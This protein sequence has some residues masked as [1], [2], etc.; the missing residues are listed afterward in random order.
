M[1]IMQIRYFGDKNYPHSQLL[2]SNYPA[3]ITA[4]DLIT[5][6]IFNKYMPVK[7]LVINALPGTRFTIDGG[8]APQVIGASGVYQVD[9]LYKT[10]SLKFEESS[11][12]YIGKNPDGYL[13]VDIIY[14]EV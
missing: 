4:Q 8:Y 10:I 12:E 11:I 7:R 14:E 5:G 9:N 13:I 3:N 1:T 6:D 2:D